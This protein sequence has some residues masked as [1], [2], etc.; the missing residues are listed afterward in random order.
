MR[1]PTAPVDLHALKRLRG[2]AQL[3]AVMGCLD[4]CNANERESLGSMLVDLASPPGE[5]RAATPLALIQKGVQRIRAGGDP[6]ALADAALFQ[7]ARSWERWSSH[8]RAEALAVGRGR[9]QKFGEVLAREGSV[10]ARTGMA[11]LAIDSM[12]A[13]LLTAM[14]VLLSDRDRGVAQI[15]ERAWIEV[16]ARLSGLDER[17]LA[18]VPRVKDALPIQCPMDEVDRDRACGALGVA[19]R[20]FPEHRCRGVLLA[21]ILLLD[22]RALRTGETDAPSDPLAAMALSREE[23]ASGSLRGFLRSS[24]LP[25]VGERA[26][27]W[28]AFPPLARAGVDRLAAVST[29]GEIDVLAQRW[30]LA[31]RPARAALLREITPGSLAKPGV[32]ASAGTPAPGAREIVRARIPMMLRATRLGPSER[33][34]A[35]EPSL[36]DPSPVVRLALAR[37]GTHRDAEDLAFDENATIAR[38]SAVI[39]SLVGTGR[40]TESTAGETHRLHVWRSLARTRNAPVRAV[41]RGE[42]ARIACWETGQLGARESVRRGLQADREGTLRIVAER[43][44]DAEPL[45]RT[46]LLATVRGVGL[47]SELEPLLVDLAMRAHDETTEFNRS[48]ATLIAALGEGKSPASLEAL[49]QAR[50]HG[51]ARVR[52]NA[53]QALGR[54]ARLDTWNTRRLMPTFI[55]LK[56]D[57]QHRVRANAL[58]SI[59]E[60]APS[61]QAGTHVPPT[62]SSAIAPTAAMEAIESLVSMLTDDRAAHRLAGVW[63]AGRT[64]HQPAAGEVSTRAPELS[65]RV[66]ELARFDADPSVRHR[67]TATAERLTRETRLGWAATTSRGGTPS[68]G[69]EAA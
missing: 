28:L 18:G 35:L 5:A 45:A 33:A 11:L 36:L 40:T 23:S 31:L 52:A 62:T 41:A 68:W 58:R 47:V 43:L 27:E 50:G 9:W 1:P 14:N 37:A 4:S 32:C 21:A 29:P 30:S 55:E 56:A 26:F 25:V 67:A 64:L 51:D 7:L 6:T 59:I 61:D 57:R 63:L 60:A 3:R 12:D 53:V 17:R 24:K 16:A 65:A 66:L 54:R 46:A 2:L 19:L 69:W 48:H 20:G 13:S 44:T 8:V 10:S 38:T 49:Q 15:A 42:L 34:R 22:A 39:A